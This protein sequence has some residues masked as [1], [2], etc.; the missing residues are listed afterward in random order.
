MW[1]GESKTFWCPG[2]L[3]RNMNNLKG[4]MEEDPCRMW[5][6]KEKVSRTNS[7]SSGGTFKKT[8][9]FTLAEIHEQSE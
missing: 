6:G 3:G 2:D 4:M 5:E 1:E 9:S 7:F 8:F